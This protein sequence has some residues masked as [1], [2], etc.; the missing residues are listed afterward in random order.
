MKKIL[1]TILI[2]S[3]LSGCALFEDKRIVIK[4][5]V[6]SKPMSYKYL[7]VLASMCMEQY[8][9]EGKTIEEVMAMLAYAEF[10]M[11]LEE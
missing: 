4:P 11:S 1:I 10:N 8:D 2:I 6:N 3:F 7:R 9:T 5:S